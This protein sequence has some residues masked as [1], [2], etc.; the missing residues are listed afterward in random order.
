MFDVNFV[1]YVDFY[2]NKSFPRK[3][4]FRPQIGDTVPFQKQMIKF[5]QYPLLVI[6][7]VIYITDDFGIFDMFECH[8]DFSKHT[9]QDIISKILSHKKI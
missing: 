3:L 7:D 1:V 5:P 8:L 6:T 9:H 2:K 4:C